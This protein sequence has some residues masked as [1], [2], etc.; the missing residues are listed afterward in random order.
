LVTNINQSFY[1]KRCYSVLDILTILHF[2]RNSQKGFVKTFTASK[3]QKPESETLWVERFGIVTSM[4]YLMTVNT[5]EHQANFYE[6][7]RSN[8]LTL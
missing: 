2:Y 1:F 5:S 7:F 6:Y 3:A 4:S 8:N